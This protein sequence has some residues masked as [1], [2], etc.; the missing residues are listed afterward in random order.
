MLQLKKE[1]G[2]YLVD[3]FNFIFDGLLLP[4]PEPT[5]GTKPGGYE[6]G[7]GTLGVRANTGED[8]RANREVGPGGEDVE[9]ATRDAAWG[10]DSMGAAG[11]AGAVGPTEAVNRAGAVGSAEAVDRAGAIGL[12]AAVG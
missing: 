9:G 11:L 6:G 4:N 10:L 3:F 12:A 5:D 1:I 8:A 7:S 2:Y